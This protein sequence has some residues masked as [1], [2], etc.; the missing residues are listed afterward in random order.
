MLR[1]PI[2][3]VFAAACLA[4]D[5]ADLFN[6]PP[7]EVDQALR[8]RI[9]EFYDLHVKKQFRKAEE[10]VAEDT[11][12]F[13]YSHDKPAY[14]SFEV[15]D[16][17]YSDNFTKAK[18]TVLCEQR[19]MFPGFADKPVKF[20]IPSTW[21]VENGKWV[22]YVDLEALR[23]SPFGKMT[24]GPEAGKSTAT[25]LP[26][27]IPN[28]FN[29]V[30]KQV[31]PDK[32]SLEL[33]PGETGQV[34]IANGAPGPMKV[35]IADKPEGIEAKL[36]KEELQAGEKVALTV[37]APKPISGTVSVQ[38]EQTGEVLPIQVVV[39]PPSI[40]LRGQL[41]V[42]KNPVELKRG[43]TAQ[44]TI[45]NRS[46]I[47]LKISFADKIAGVQASLSAEEVPPGEKSSLTLRAGTK[48]VSGTIHIRAAQTAEV[49][50]I[51]V[52]VK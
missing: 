31:K 19:V 32:D 46:P 18:A 23:Q 14:L 49:L 36:A 48:P 1:F 7:L 3:L 4:Q 24:A 41:S 35:V 28:D 52:N 26:A 22:W 39:K 37:R 30:L 38:V 17:K 11:K 20:P 25:G 6:K 27:T 8:A 12:D 13:F 40:P 51:R 10:L 5:P 44:I 34:T 33:K 47:A 15:K 21:K 43:E 50:A 9:N 2:L 29:F 42:S 45:I 16:I